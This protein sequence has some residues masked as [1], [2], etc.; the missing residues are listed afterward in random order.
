MKRKLRPT[1]CISL[2]IT[3]DPEV[4]GPFLKAFAATPRGK[5]AALV[6]NWLR[7]GYHQLAQVEEEETQ[8]PTAWV[9]DLLLD[10]QDD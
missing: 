8:R 5:R 10:M 4:D 7:A 9:E 1:V 6:R 3:F 2:R